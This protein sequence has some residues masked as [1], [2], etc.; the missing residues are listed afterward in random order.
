[1]EE[2][3]PCKVLRKLGG[4]RDD[5]AGGSEGWPM[6]VYAAVCGHLELE[7]GR[8]IA[9]ET[10]TIRIPV[11]SYV[12]EH[13]QGVV[14]FDSGLRAGLA[15]AADP[16]H[17]RQAMDKIKVELPRGSD[18]ASRLASLGHDVTDVRY[19]INSHL[20]FDHC[21]GNH[22]I[23]NAPL[24]IQKREWEAGHSPELCERC[25]Y[26]RS[27]YDL[28]HDILAIDGDHDV[29][30]DGSVTCFLTHGHTPGHQ[31]VKVK[32]PG[33][34]VVLTA[35]ACYFRSVLEKLT[36]PRRVFDREVMLASLMRLRGLQDAGATLHFGHDTEY[37]YGRSGT[38]IELSVA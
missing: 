20:H 13:P 11:P 33:G 18:L 6:R 19:L 9:G 7:L 17:A 8:M 22:L 4:C 3:K 29:F 32:L 36:L 34:D 35:D 31:S 37:W 2:R 10:G 16:E 5:R 1:M 21:G 14:V 27:D 38:P 23:P 30:G 25:G 24:V 28:G 15:D 12:I 26:A